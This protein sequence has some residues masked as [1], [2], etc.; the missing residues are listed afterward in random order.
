MD[1]TQKLVFEHEVRRFNSEGI[2]KSEDWQSCRIGSVS[3][4]TKKRCVMIADML[5]SIG[6]A[7]G[8]LWVYVSIDNYKYNRH[9]LSLTLWILL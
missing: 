3:S 5:K 1:G 2:A 4:L 6:N 8:F 9:L 7:F